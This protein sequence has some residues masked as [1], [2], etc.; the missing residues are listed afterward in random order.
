MNRGQMIWKNFAIL[1]RRAP[2]DRRAGRALFLTLLALVGLAAYAALVLLNPGTYVI[3]PPALIALWFIRRS[4][5]RADAGLIRLNRLDVKS[6]TDDLLEHRKHLAQVTVALAAMIDRAG[7]EAFLKSKELPPGVAVIT[8][9]RLIAMLRS[10]EIWDALPLISRERMMLPDGGWDWELISD[11]LRQLEDLRVLRWVLRI[12]TYLL[13][14]DQAYKVHL[15]LATELTGDSAKVRGD[16]CLQAWEMEEARKH[17]D[18]YFGRCWAEEQ[19]RGVGVAP[20]EEPSDQV[21]ATET[22]LSSEEIIRYATELGSQQSGD[23]L[24]G[25]GIV[26]DASDEQLKNATMV[27]WRR[28]MALHR[29]MRYLRGPSDR[30]E[31]IIT[32]EFV[33]SAGTPLNSGFY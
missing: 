33:D 28:T 3:L 19:K 15:S 1:V 14:I 11:A 12:D 2:K 20:Q 30:I 18:S 26:G 32:N 25:F 23:F 22:H 17:A 10:A 16:G 31:R 29:I 6:E 7:S 13:P 4:H 5:K 24:L 8:R 9:Q 21:E 27:A